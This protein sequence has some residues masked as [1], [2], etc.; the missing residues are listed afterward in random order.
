MHIAFHCNNGYTNAARCYA[1]LTLPVFYNVESVISPVDGSC[2]IYY[3]PHINENIRWK[4]WNDASKE[5]NCNTKQLQDVLIFMNVPSKP[6]NLNPKQFQ[7]IDLCNKSQH[8]TPRPPKP[9]VTYAQ[10]D[11]VVRDFIS[12]GATY[13]KLGFLFYFSYFVIA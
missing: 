7:W 3:N 11:G 5:T 13:M 4:F 2:F 1:V 6:K 12:C 9:Y 10:K 8:A